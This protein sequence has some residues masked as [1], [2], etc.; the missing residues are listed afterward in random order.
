[1]AFYL[2][3]GGAG[4]IGSN[5]SEYL[6]KNGHKVRILDDFSSGKLENIAEFAQHIEIMEGDVRDLDTVKKSAKG[7]DYVLHHAA[8]ASVPGS[9]KNPVDTNQINVEG[10]LN[11]LVAARDAGVKRVVFASSSSVYG[12]GEDRPRNEAIMPNPLSPYAVTKLVGELYAKEFY[13]SYGLET[14]SLRYFNV[15]GPKQNPKSQ[16]SGVIS[17][18]AD[19]LMKDRA[20]IIFGDGEQTRDFV[21]VDNI[22]EA[23][24]LAVQSDKIGR[25]EIINIGSGKGITLNGIINLMNNILGKNIRPAYQDARRGDIKRSVADISLAEKLLDYNVRVNL[26][27]GLNTLLTSN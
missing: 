16:Y 21:H 19:N 7:V 25:G 27:E 4:F 2:V 13:N 14:V 20:P 5:L 15:F 6:L 12:D 11:V 10:T 24:I 9:I 26:A 22:I 18:F 23:N 17:I 3:T 1:M 8:L